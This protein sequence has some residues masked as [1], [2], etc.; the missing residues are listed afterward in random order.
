MST[1]AGEITRIQGGVNDVWDY[2]EDNGVAIPAG[3]T[4]DEA[5]I[6]LNQIPHGAQS[7]LEQSAKSL[8]DINYMFQ[9]LKVDDIAKIDFMNNLLPL[10]DNCK[11]MQHTFAYI[12][13]VA[14]NV[15]LNLLQTIDLSEYNSLAYLFSNMIPADNQII[16]LTNIQF[17]GNCNSLFYNIQNYNT[18]TIKFNEDTFKNC[19]NINSMFRYIT[20]NNFSLDYIHNG[21]DIMDFSNTENATSLFM[22]CSGKIKNNGT[23]TT[24]LNLKFKDGIT[25]IAGMLNQMANDLTE[26]NFYG[27]LSSVTSVE[28]LNYRGNNNLIKKI[29]GLDC[30]SITSTSNIGGANTYK[31]TSL[32]EFGIVQ[33][34]TVGGNHIAN[35]TLNLQYIWEGITTDIRDGQTIGYWYEKFANALGSVTGAS[36]TKTIKINTTLYNSLTQAQKELITDK[37]YTLAYAS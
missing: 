30:S 32:G 20:S 12:D 10:L 37:G 26:I 14:V 25:S 27:D 18:F 33:G 34:S 15:V 5:R 2:C 29:T 21:N 19:T 16:D 24:K 17:Y 28:F 8:Q 11:S 6:Y 4:V 3:T 22:Q 13:G 23:Q 31:L 9:Y 7:A 1:I 36:G 35:C